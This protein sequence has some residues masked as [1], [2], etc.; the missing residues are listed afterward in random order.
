MVWR[1]W[2]VAALHLMKVWM[3]TKVGKR[4]HEM[5]GRAEIIGQLV[6]ADKGYYKFV[7]NFLF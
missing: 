3:V 2:W 1:V 6:V 5:E 7:Q 4:Y